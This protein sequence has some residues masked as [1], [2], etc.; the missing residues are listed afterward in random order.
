MLQWITTIII[1]GIAAFV[2]LR[3][4][5]YP[6]H[7]DKKSSCNSCESDACN[8]CPLE[9][10]KKEIH[11]KNSDKNQKLISNENP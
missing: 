6:A 2:I 9:D 5:F 11:L 1:L 7:S 10:L 4:L 3:K 8:T